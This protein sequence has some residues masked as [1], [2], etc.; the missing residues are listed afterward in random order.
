M[1]R[2][3]IRLV[4]LDRSK[5]VKENDS[6]KIFLDTD[7]QVQLTQEEFLKSGTVYKLDAQ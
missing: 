4:A 3:S 5:L 1:Q 2:A 7:K 6:W